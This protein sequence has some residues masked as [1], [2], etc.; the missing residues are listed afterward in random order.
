MKVLNKLYT[1]E[2]NLNKNIVLISDIHYSSNKDL[3]RLNF[4]LNRIKKINP[5]YICIPGDIID[6]SKIDD[7][8]DFIEWLKKLSSIT[9]VIVSIGN[10][11]FYIDKSKNILGLN[12]TLFKKISN[13]N[14]LYLLDNKN[15]II[16][17]INF[18]GITV[19]LK[20]YTNSNEFYKCMNKVKTNK[21]YYNI[22]L[23]HSPENICNKN[24][25]KD[26]NIDL[27][28]CG[29]MHGGVVF[30]FLRPIFKNTGLIGP[31]KK[32]FPKNAYGHIKIN[33]TN[34]VI[35]SGT[36]VLPYKVLNKLFKP[37]IVKIS[38]TFNKN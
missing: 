29:H 14:N 37:E 2:S 10:H 5:D 1:I 28:L 18:I 36:R 16:D 13:I 19:P 6:K 32:I 11:E 20:Y 34:I 26:K 30:N 7:E 21:K 17:N 35:T 8:E 3:N 27:I 38:L 24:I 15:I 33:D 23:C 9:K 22:L 25:I 31:T 4:I 12:K